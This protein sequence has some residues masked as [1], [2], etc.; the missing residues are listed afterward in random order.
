MILVTGGTG[1][2][3]SHLLYKLT[4]TQD[5]VRAL[6]RNE[7]KLSAVKHVFSYFTDNIDPQFSKIEW[8]KGDILD[9]PLL[10]KH[11]HT[12]TR[13]YHCAA[14]VSFAPNEYLNL[15]KTN[16][17]GTANIVNLCISNKIEKLCYVSSIAAIGEEKP[18]LRITE[19]S[20]WN[21]EANHSVYAITKYGAEMEVWRGTQEGLNSVVVNPGIILGGGFWR[22]GSGSLFKKVYKGMNYF[23]L[24]KT[25]YVDIQDVINIM[26]KLMESGII[27]ERFI[28][29]SENWSFKEFTQQ[30]ATELKVKIPSKEIKSWQLNIAWRLDWLRSVFMNK[31][32]RI[33]KQTANS[34]QLESLYSNSKILDTL[35]Y[36]FKSINSSVKQVSQ[37]FLRDC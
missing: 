29:V 19:E 1:L 27:N 28:I 36:E 5:K 17:E 13:V 2:V 31:R 8:V 4:Q 16:I 10:E 7:E 11:F 18:G 22:T 34:I 32:R 12:I 14:L 37:L 30:V 9:I 23:A 35:D 24:G 25:G 3:G 21:S 15:R 20:P 33:T 6:Y 26:I